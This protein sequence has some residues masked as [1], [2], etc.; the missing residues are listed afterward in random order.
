MQKQRSAYSVNK[1]LT[2]CPG[3]KLKYNVS[4]SILSIQPVILGILPYMNRIITYH[5]LP[6]IKLHV[7]KLHKKHLQDLLGGILLDIRKGI[8]IEKTV[9]PDNEKGC[10][11]IWSNGAK[12]ASLTDYSQNIKI[13]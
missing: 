3:I 5:I 8:K 11:F 10:S 2:F 13:I 1:T 7:Y 12:A 9:S 4:L 6:I